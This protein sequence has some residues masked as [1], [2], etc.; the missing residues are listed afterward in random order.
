MQWISDIVN[1]TN[2]IL[3]TYI[4]IVL[5]IAAGLYFSFG[6]KFVQIRLFG[7]MFRLIVEKKERENLAFLHSRP[8]RLAQ[9]LA[10]VLVISQG[11]H[12]LLV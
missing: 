5:L 9:P 12:S 3:W 7:E 10:L 6:T 11:W 4:L 2:D 1:S 8:L